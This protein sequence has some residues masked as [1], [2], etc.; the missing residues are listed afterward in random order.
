MKHV[1]L[2]PGVPCVLFCPAAPRNYVLSLSGAAQKQVFAY[3]SDCQLLSD[4]LLE[5]GRGH[6]GLSMMAASAR[7]KSHSKQEFEGKQLSMRKAI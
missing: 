7:L 4:F 5:G 1:L 3:F 6:T 2:V